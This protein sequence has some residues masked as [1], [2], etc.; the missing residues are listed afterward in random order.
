M[1]YLDY[2]IAY[3]RMLALARS[4]IGLTPRYDG[5]RR[6]SLRNTNIYFTLFLSNL[7]KEASVYL[8]ARD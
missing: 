5:N 8:N 4:T 3:T 2:L 6:E 7:S 1:Y